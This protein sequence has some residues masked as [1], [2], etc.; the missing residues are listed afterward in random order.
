MNSTGNKYSR[1]V[2]FKRPLI[3][4]IVFRMLREKSFYNVFPAS[5]YPVPPGESQKLQ[6]SPLPTIVEHFSVQVN[7]RVVEREQLLKI[8]CLVKT[9]LERVWISPGKIGGIT[10][11]FVMLCKRMAPNNVETVTTTFP[12]NRTHATFPPRRVWQSSVDR[13]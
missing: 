3:I 10:P 6:W 7:C 1:F 13:A 12:S 9:V 4:F 5:A 2:K 11:L 8:E